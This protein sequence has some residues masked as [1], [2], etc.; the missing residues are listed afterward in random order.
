[1]SHAELAVHLR[2]PPILRGLKG[3]YESVPFGTARPVTGLTAEWESCKSDDSEGPHCGYPANS[4]WE[5]VTQVRL[6]LAALLPLSLFP[7]KRSVFVR[8]LCADK[9]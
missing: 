7:V 3:S 6:L 5:L 2:L 4:N 8:L 9:P 1:M